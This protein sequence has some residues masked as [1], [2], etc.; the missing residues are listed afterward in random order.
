MFDRKNKDIQ[1]IEISFGLLVGYLIMGLVNV[2]G[3]DKNWKEAFSDNTIIVGTVGIVTSVIVVFIAMKK[4]KK[5][6]K[7]EETSAPLSSSSSSLLS[8]EALRER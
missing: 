3:F 2:L 6:D 5:K 8:Y 7:K 1:T 4:G